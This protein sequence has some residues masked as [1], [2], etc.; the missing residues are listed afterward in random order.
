[1]HLHVSLTIGRSISV[2]QLAFF[3]FVNLHFFILVLLHTALHYKG[4]HQAYPEFVL[5]DSKIK[6]DQ[7]YVTTC[8]KILFL[9]MHMLKYVK[10]HFNICA[11]AL[12]MNIFDLF[13]NF[14]SICV[15]LNSFV[16]LFS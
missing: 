15:A 16:P 6:Y 11:I 1:M 9:T 5:L 4:H 3:V 14:G 12:W 8:L 7:T 10:R 2:S 13:C